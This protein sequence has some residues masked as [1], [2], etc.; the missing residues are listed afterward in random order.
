MG[1]CADANRE[2]ANHYADYVSTSLDDRRLLGASVE[3]L[4][5]S[6]RE[7]YGWGPFRAIYDATLSG[8][9][10]YL[11]E[12]S[13]D[14]RDDEM[15]LFLSQQVGE[16]LIDF[17]E[18]ELGIHPSDSV[19]AT[20][21]DLPVSDLTVLASLPCRTPTLRATPSAL[22]LEA[23]AANPSPSGTLY[24]Q[25]PSAWGVSLAAPASWLSLTRT[26]V[27]DATTVVLRVDA[28]ALPAGATANT[29]VVL[30]GSDLA[31]SPLHVPVTLHVQ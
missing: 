16:S 27:S 21:A 30:T 15:V 11:G 3:P 25:A 6:L 23:D 1:Y 5:L 9:L 26:D 31:N 29:E 12:L 22:M 4:L 20:L 17:F 13:S 19:R 8:Q 10:D 7:R 24:V 2:H 14:Q 18:R 28:S